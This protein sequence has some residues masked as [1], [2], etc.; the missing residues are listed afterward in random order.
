MSIAITSFAR[1]RLFPKKSKRNTIQNC[2]PEEFVQYVNE[3]EPL[4]LVDGYAP[5]CKLGVYQNWT[6]TRCLTV[7]ITDGNRHLLRS[8]Y[9][10]RTPSE[11]PVLARWF[12]FE[13]VEV[14]VAAFLIVILYSRDQLQKEGE[15]VQ[16]DWGIVGCLYTSAPKEIPMTPATILRNALGV[17][18]GGSDVSLD[19]MAYRHS[20]AFWEKNAVWRYS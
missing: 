3:H 16:E 13:D 9:E 11:L 4:K 10:H 12:E 19:R 1:N 5:F 14:P 7:P 20:V 6:S 8:G 18:E 17:E 2:S 15:R